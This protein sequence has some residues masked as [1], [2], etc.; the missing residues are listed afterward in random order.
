MRGKHFS[1][2]TVPTDTLSVAAQANC[3][4]CRGFVQARRDS[5]PP[6]PSPKKLCGACARCC[7]TRQLRLHSALARDLTGSAPH[8]PGAPPGPACTGCGHP[9]AYSG[10][11][12][13]LS[14]CQPRCMRSRA[15]RA[16]GPR[17]M[18]APLVR[19]RPPGTRMSCARRAPRATAARWTPGGRPHPCAPRPGPQIRPAS[20]LFGQ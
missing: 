19:A 14:G 7:S 8:R 20:C 10:R 13:M 2:V 3:R 18:L 17:S 12:L 5:P 4:G 6:P 1:V 16:G 15:M 11:L 9:S